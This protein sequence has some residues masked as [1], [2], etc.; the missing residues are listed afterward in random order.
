[1]KK[2]VLN[3]RGIAEIAIFAAIA[4][5]LDFIQE[6]VFDF[7]PFFAN[8]GSIGFASIPVILIGL[9]RGVIAGTLCGLITSLCQML[10][11]ITTVNAQDF[12]WYLVF[13]QILLDYVLTYTVV[14]LFAGIFYHLLDKNKTIKY[15]LLMV[16]FASIISGLAKFLCHFLAGCIFWQAFSIFDTPV[17][18]PVYSLV[19]NGL[20][21]F[22]NI[23]IALICLVILY[24]KQSRFFYVNDKIS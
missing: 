18:A 7:I 23:I 4:F 20:Y 22:P 14:G 15:N 2:S 3:T 6:K 8:G 10:G 19:Y 5:I 11:G 9:R 21:S 17:S 24:L 13:L 16:S 12:A 1:M